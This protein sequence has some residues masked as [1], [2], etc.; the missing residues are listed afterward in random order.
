M[1]APE[2]QRPVYCPQCWW[3]D[4]WDG[5]DYGVEYDPS[6]PFLAQLLELDMKVPHMSLSVDYASLVNSEYVNYSGHVKDCYLVFIADFCE[7]VLYSDILANDKDSMD[8]LMLD[9]SELCYGVVSG[10]RNSRLFF[11][12]DCADCTEVY[13]SK[14]CRGCNNCFGCFGLRKKSYCFFNQPLEKEEYHRKVEQYRLDSYEELQKIKNETHTFW[15]KFPHKFAHLGARNT[16]VTGDY[17]F[18]ASKNAHYIFYGIGVENSRYCQIMTVGPTQDSYDITSWGNNLQRSIEGVS[19]GEGADNIK[20]TMQAWPGVMDIE[21]SIWAVSSS[22]IFGCAG[23][24]KK[25]YCILN[26]QYSKEEFEE[27]RNKIRADMSRNPYRDAQG[28][29]YPYGEFLPMDLS[30]HAYNESE[31]MSYFPLSKAEALARGY[32][33]REPDPSP[34]KPT[35]KATDLPDSI[36]DV[37][38]EIVKE[39]IECAE[40]AR[41]FKMIPAE[42]DLLRRFELPLPRKCSNCRH[43]ER[44]ARVNPPRLYARNCAKCQA[45]IQTSYPPDR[46]EIVYCENCYNSEVA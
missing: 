43:R 18:T 7:N 38:D 13:F 36:K 33:W 6:R 2:D 27:L 23:V 20:Y 3:S 5:L 30:P 24:R 19:V 46:P 16:N 44:M 32:R 34:H 11:S 45:S 10:G 1:F 12:E 14:D 4:K 42:L 41:A 37:S 21:Y 29:A 26:K 39:V 35:I 8:C 15:L 25:E 17:I 28:R 40:C 31:A 9:H 22:H